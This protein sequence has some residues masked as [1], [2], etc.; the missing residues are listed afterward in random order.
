M[1]NLRED[2]LKITFRMVQQACQPC[3]SRQMLKNIISFFLFARAS[4]ERSYQKTRKGRAVWVRQTRKAL[5]RKCEMLVGSGRF[6]QQGWGL[7]NFR[8]HFMQFPRITKSWMFMKKEKKKWHWQCSQISEF[9]IKT[10]E[11]RTIRQHRWCATGPGES[12]T[13][14]GFAQEVFNEF[15][16]GSTNVILER[17]HAWKV[18]IAQDNQHWLWK[19]IKTEDD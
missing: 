6:L 15:R 11:S 13:V 3:R 8:R 2:H 18:N 1:R 12:R 9:G 7:T 14:R 10:A 16:W 17:Y 5:S 19:S 4:D